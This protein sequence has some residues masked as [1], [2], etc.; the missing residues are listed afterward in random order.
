M[1]ESGQGLAQRQDEQPD[2]RK[3][4]RILRERAPHVG[5]EIKHYRPGGDTSIVKRLSEEVAAIAGVA[6]VKPI[7]P[8]ML[9]ALT[10]RALILDARV[11]YR[12]VGTVQHIGNGVATLSGLPRSCTDELVTFPTGVQGLIL[13]LERDHV[14]VILL[15]SDQGI[16]GGDQVLATGERLQI[17]VGRNLLGRVV[18]PLGQPL[19]ERGSIEAVYHTHLEHD[20]PGIIDREPVNQP[21]LTGWK[22]VDAL[23]PIGRGQRELI[24]GDRQTGKTTLA[25]PSSR[26]IRTG[27]LSIRP[28]STRTIRFMRTGSRARG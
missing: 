20:A 16:Q 18:N 10:E 23:V 15:G 12:A 22:M 8:R 11:Q 1:S 21:L 9:Q 25:A 27:A 13:N 5:A 4:L 24:I 19:D 17:P 3:M 28:P 2:V 14:D 26:A 7:I 6:A